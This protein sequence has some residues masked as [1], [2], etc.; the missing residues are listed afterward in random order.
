MEFAGV[1]CAGFYKG[2]GA[3]MEYWNIIITEKS[4]RILQKIR[5]EINFVLI[6]GWAAYLWT[7]SH[8]SK[9]IDI[10][11]DFKELYNLKFNYNLKKNDALKKYE[12]TVDEVDIDIYVPF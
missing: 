3:K 9:D 5:K 7:K 1:V 12:I 10:V 4:W 11:V 8:K 2:Y 6:G